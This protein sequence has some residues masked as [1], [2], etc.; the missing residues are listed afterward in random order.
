MDEKNSNNWIK[1]AI[2]VDSKQ[3]SILQIPRMGKI[4]T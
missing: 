2:V 1:L 4:I 3:T